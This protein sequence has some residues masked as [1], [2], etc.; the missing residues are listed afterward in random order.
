VLSTIGAPAVCLDAD[1]RVTFCNQALLALTGWRREEVV[2]GDW[3]GR[4]VPGG[5]D[6]LAA[7][8][9]AGGEAAAPYEADVITRGGEPRTVQWS[10]TV[11]RD[12]D[13][14]PVGSASIGQDVTAHVRAARAKDEALGLASHDLRSPLA[15]VTASLQLLRLELRGLDGP[16]L[17]LLDMASRNAERAV[18]LVD[19]LVDVRRG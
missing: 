8:D 9:A 19:G 2:G 16:G 4:F 10:S 5:R 15:A 6:P 13:G 14:R 12:G 7:P 18:R 11:L 3:F 17:H 1:G